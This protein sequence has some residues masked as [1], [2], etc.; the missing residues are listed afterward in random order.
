MSGDAAQVVDFDAVRELEASVWSMFSILGWGT[1]GRV[2]DTPTR[3]VVETPVP[4]PPYNTVWRFYD[5]GDRPLAHQVDEVLTPMIERGVTAGWVVH[6]TTS[7]GVREE[8]TA[9]GW[10]R[11]E[12]I[13]GMVAD[14]AEIDSP[15]PVPEGVEVVEVSTCDSEIWLE[16]VSWRYGLGVESNPYLREV[17][18]KVIGRHTRVWVAIVD[19]AP[20]SKVALHISSGV[21]GIYGVV[22][23]ESGRGRGLASLLTL[24]ALD[25]ARSDGVSRTV[26]HSTPMARSLYRRLGY[27]DVA[28]FEVWAEPGSMTAVTRASRVRRRDSCRCPWPADRG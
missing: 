4:R 22:T 24:T 6:P 26:L 23:T 7:P 8:L 10:V 25:A 12:E 5:E 28:T 19:G 27:R 16:L 3:L 17:Y 18:E 2:L 9:I 1:G 14:L 21:A 20:M 11:A 15:P 13:F